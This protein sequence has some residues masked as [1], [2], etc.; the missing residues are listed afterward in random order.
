[1]CRVSILFPR[2][3]N[4]KK[5]SLRTESGTQAESK[6]GQSAFFDCFN[7]AVVGASTAADANVGIDDE[8]VFTLG[9]S[10]YGAVVGARATL[11]ASI[12][13]FVSHDFPSNMFILCILW[14]ARLF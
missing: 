10:L 2:Y 12:G 8:L 6:N 11:D 9:N 1:L 14:N 13:N 5:I 3:R 4:D 7:G